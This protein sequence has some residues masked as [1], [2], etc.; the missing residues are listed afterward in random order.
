MV[1][2][3]LSRAID[4]GDRIGSLREMPMEKSSSSV[5][6]VCFD[7]GGV[8]VRIARGWDDACRRAG[9]ALPHADD[10]AWARHHELMLRYET[11]A[12]GEEDYLCE[13]PGVIG[14]GVEA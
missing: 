2:R 9:V 1:A 5:R 14:G 10:A 7:L 4:S 11:G 6:L 13:A 3:S 12:I 8:L